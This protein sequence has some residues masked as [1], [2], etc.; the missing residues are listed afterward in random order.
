L[1]KYNKYFFT[2]IPLTSSAKDDTF[3]YKFN[4][5]EN[6]DSFAILSQIK[7]F[8]ANRLERKIGKISKT[9]FIKLKEK[10]KILLKL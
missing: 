5:L 6:K 1:R 3:Y 9:D 8:D 10:L 2:G 4:F 7:S